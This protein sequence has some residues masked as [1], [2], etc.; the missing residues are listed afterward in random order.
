MDLIA[1]RDV[2]THSNDH[3]YTYIIHVDS[4]NKHNNEPN[5]QVKLWAVRTAPPQK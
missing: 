2:F 1:H 5:L 4:Y 3:L